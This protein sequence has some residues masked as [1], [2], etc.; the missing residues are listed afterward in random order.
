MPHVETLLE[1]FGEFDLIP[2]PDADALMVEP[3][4]W[5]GAY[6]ENYEISTE[7]VATA[8]EIADLRNAKSAGGVKWDRTISAAQLSED[9]EA[10]YKPDVSRRD[11]LTKTLAWLNSRGESAIKV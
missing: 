10:A 6:D 3:A 4:D 11:R 7:L 1:L 5:S 9:D 8:E 2:A